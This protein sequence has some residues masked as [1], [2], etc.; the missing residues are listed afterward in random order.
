MNPRISKLPRKGRKQRPVTVS[1]L[2]GRPKREECWSTEMEIRFLNRMGN[3]AKHRISNTSATD[4]LRA[5][6]DAALKRKDWGTINARRILK[7]VE[8][9]LTGQRRSHAAV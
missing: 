2:P 4:L 5:Y 6:R 7:H 9:L 8:W 3:H 1:Y